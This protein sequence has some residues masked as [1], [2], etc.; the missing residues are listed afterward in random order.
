MRDRLAHKYALLD[1]AL[2]WAVV[3]RDLPQL[4]LATVKLLKKRS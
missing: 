1:K 3:E 2:V 4:R